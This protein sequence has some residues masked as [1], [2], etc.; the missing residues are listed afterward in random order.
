MT[1]EDPDERA[2]KLAGRFSPSGTEQADQ[3]NQA[4]ETHE[5]S[6]APDASKASNTQKTPATHETT[7]T[8]E[9]EGPIRE[10]KTKLLYL[11]EDFLR[12]LELTFDELNLRYKREYG[13]ALQKN[14]DFY[15][16]LL[17][18]GLEQLGDIRERDLNDIEAILDLP[19]GGS[20]ND[21]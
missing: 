16:N 17:R 15:P 20:G 18:L 2:E 14:R 19:Q 8:D 21:K 13:E 1:D 12:E 5:A 4:S 7:E 10:Q 3:T 11:D 6:Q 9:G